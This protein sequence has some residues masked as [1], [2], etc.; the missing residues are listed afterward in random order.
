M[1][2]TRRQLLSLV[3]QSAPGLAL[4]AWLGR[5]LPVRGAFDCDIDSGDVY[6]RLARAAAHYIAPTPEEALRVAQEL[7]F[8]PGSAYEHPSQLCGPLSVAIL[9]DARLVAVDTA[10]SEFWLLNPRVNWP[11]LKAT[12]PEDGFVHLTIR[13]SL[14]TF[15]FRRWPLH[16]GDFLYLYAG[17]GGTFEHM[18]TVS[19]VDAD[20]RAFA[21]TNQRMDDDTYVIDDY[22]LYDPAQP[23]TGQFYNWTGGYSRR[24]GWTG[25]GGFEVFRPRAGAVSAADPALPDSARVRFARVART[26]LGE[27]GGQW[28]VL[29]QEVGNALRAGPVWLASR[30]DEPLHP[31]STIK[32]V[33]G[34]LALQWLAARRAAD[35]TFD[36]TQVGYAGRS[37]A[38]LLRAM[39]VASEETATSLLTEWLHGELGD[40]GVRAQLDALGLVQTTLSPRVSTVREMA[41]LMA[42]L[43]N[44]LVLAPAERAL[45]LGYLQEY[46]EPDR[47]RLGMLAFRP[48]SREGR[49]LVVLNKRGTITDELLVVADL[50]LVGVPRRGGLMTWFVVGVFGYQ[51]YDATYERLEAGLKEFVDSLYVNCLAPEMN[52]P[53]GGG[54]KPGCVVE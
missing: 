39:L 31:A 23:E 41:G 36:M 14:A 29:V 12:F 10:I 35:S 4:A 42:G 38:Q 45:L 32:V 51:A 33:I 15:D 9:R 18:L 34:V 25:F 8:L 13:E 44:G 40:D 5:P 22:L 47:T 21:V 28:H 19:R 48:Y 49:Q 3:V 46:S 52:W 54:G 26:A 2:L 7:N 37:Y 30:L 16:P 43:A 27:S 11:L 20:G 1:M 24:L 6:G 53:S 50:G 17:V